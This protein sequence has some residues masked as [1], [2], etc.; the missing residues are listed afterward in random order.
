M[1]RIWGPLIGRQGRSGQTR[2]NIT[3]KIVTLI[4]RTWTFN[5]SEKLGKTLQDFVQWSDRSFD[6]V[7]T[8]CFVEKHILLEYGWTQR[9]TNNNM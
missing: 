7:L 2:V 8:M 5:L 9:G 3:E 6:C 4:V 1:V